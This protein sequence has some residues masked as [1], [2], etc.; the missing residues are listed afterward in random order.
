MVT[1]AV[2]GGVVDRVA[3]AL[4]L[5]LL[6]VVGEARGSRQMPARGITR[7][8]SETVVRLAVTTSDGATGWS[9][10]RSSM[11]V[12][13]DRTS[14][15]ARSSTRASG[16]LTAPP[17]SGE[18]AGSAPMKHGVVETSSPSTTRLLRET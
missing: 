10:A 15:R 16:R 17:R 5:G 6:D 12:G 7:S 9:R 11:S 8:P 13:S 3:E 2:A 1:I 4:Q 18:A 14:W